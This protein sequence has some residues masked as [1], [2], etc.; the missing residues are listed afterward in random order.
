MAATLAPA[1][2]NGR[3]APGWKVALDLAPMLL[4]HAGA[5]GAIW[6]GATWADWL[7]FPFVLYLR[8]LLVTGGY[9]RF[10]AHR[11]FKTTRFGQ[12]VIGFLCCANLQQG[13]LWWAGYHRHHHRHSDDPADV[14][15]PYHGGFFWAYCG[16]LFKPLA[17]P[18]KYVP[19]L[20]RYPELVWLERF[21]QVPGLLL[22]G[23]CFWVGGWGTLCV[24]FCL[25]TVVTFHLTFAVNTLGHLVG[26]RRYPTKDHSTNSFLLACLTMGDGWHNNHHHCP[27]AAQAGF[28][29]WEWD[30]AYRAIRA[31]EMLGLVWDV[32]RV[33]AH[34]LHPKPVGVPAVE[35]AA[36]AS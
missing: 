2:D 34:R 31:L 7:V 27:N 22:A 36:T 28:F 26:S 33:P 24:V 21:W 20:R 18:W 4:A 15:S 35:E 10:F 17:A 23:L 5:V 3:A 9:H 1:L 30:G 25:S 19:D 14:H 11:A 13:P 32:R 6:A 29:W 12:F 16:W 8:G